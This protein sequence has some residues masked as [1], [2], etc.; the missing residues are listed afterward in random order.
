MFAFSKMCLVGQAQVGLI[1]FKRLLTIRL[2]L[3]NFAFQCSRLSY[4]SRVTFLGDTS[5]FVATLN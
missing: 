4:M 1:L 5:I 3:L 2:I